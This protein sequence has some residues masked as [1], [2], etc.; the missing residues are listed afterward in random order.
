MGRSNSNVDYTPVEWPI[1]DDNTHTNYQPLD[2]SVGL[3]TEEFKQA[4]RDNIDNQE[5]A[6]FPKD[7]K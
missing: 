5:D 1:P 7:K 6:M 2:A 3:T 4:I